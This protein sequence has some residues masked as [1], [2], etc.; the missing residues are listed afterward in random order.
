[1][2]LDSFHFILKLA[3]QLHWFWWHSGCAS[4]LVGL[5]VTDVEYWVELVEPTLQVQ[6]VGSGSNLL[7]DLEWSNPAGVQLAGSR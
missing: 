1:M 2:C 6:L 5:Q 4:S 3:L 7:G